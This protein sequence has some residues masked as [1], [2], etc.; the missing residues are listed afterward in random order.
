MAYFSPKRVYKKERTSI[1]IDT[2]KLRKLDALAA[3]LHISRNELINQ[4]IDY[5]LVDIAVKKVLR[6]NTQKDTPNG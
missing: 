6:L 2:A 5:A 4:C 3:S 1:R